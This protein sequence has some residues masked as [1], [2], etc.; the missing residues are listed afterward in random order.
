MFTDVFFLVKKIFKLFI[1]QHTP[2]LYNVQ[3]VHL[4]IMEIERYRDNEP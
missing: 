3:N 2:V 1:Y 4:Y